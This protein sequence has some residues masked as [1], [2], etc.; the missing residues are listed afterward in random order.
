MSMG[1]DRPERRRHGPGSRAADDSPSTLAT[2][3]EQVRPAVRD[4]LNT[5]LAQRRTTGFKLGEAAFSLSWTTV[6]KRLQTGVELSFGADRV[7]L[8]VDSFAA[9]DP[10]LIGGPFH[11][12]PSTVRKLVI[13]R[14]AAEFIVRLPPELAESADLTTVHWSH[15]TLPDWECRLGF[16]LLR[17]G[18]DTVSRG[19]LATETPEV[20]LRLHR[21]LP[22]GDA[23]EGHAPRGVPVPLHV[24]LGTTYLG[25]AC[26]ADLAPGDVVWI[27]D[28]RITAAGLAATLTSADGSRHWPCLAKHRVVRLVETATTTLPASGDAVMPTDTRTLELPVTFDLADVR[29]PLGELDSLQPGSLLELPNEA[30]DADVRLRIAGSLFA[31][32]KLVVI[33]RRLG[34]RITEVTAGT[35]VEG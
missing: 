13:E 16:A 8:A 7:M 24:R 15:R 3:L 35:G 12:A 32:G 11:H 9:L 34:V 4:A 26:V 2:H 10:L 22:A 18:A 29:L 5:W 1:A 23:I 25:R 20:L 14:L 30:V 21:L 17:T 19:L 6:P 27:E 33:G 31:R 28:G